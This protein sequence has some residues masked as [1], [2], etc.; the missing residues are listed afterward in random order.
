M[1]GNKN[2]SGIVGREEYKMTPDLIAPLW[3]LGSLAAVM[4]TEWIVLIVMENK[5]MKGG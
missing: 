5:K 2:G 4:I 3:V 1:D